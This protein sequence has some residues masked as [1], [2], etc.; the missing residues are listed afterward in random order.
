MVAK[1]VPSM[2]KLPEQNVFSVMVEFYRLKTIAGKDMDEHQ[3]NY[4]VIRLVT[5]IEQFFRCIVEN[6]LRDRSIPALEKVELDTRIIDEVASSVSRSP[7]STIKNR[8]ISLTY[9]FQSTKAI[10]DKFGEAIDGAEK[11]NL[12]KLF[13]HRHNLVHSVDPSP[14]HS[15]EIC[16]H[17]DIVE[18]IMK[19]VLDEQNN[20]DFSFYIMKGQS[21]HRL[22]DDNGSKE[23]FENALNCFNRRVKLNPDNPDLHFGVGLAHWYLGGYEAANRSFD[24]ATRLKPDFAEAHLHRGLMLFLLDR[25]EAAKTSFMDVIKFDPDNAFALLY[26]SLTENAIGS[27]QNA[28]AYLDRAII[29]EPGNARLYAE[30][31]DILR[32]YGM[33]VWADECHKLASMRIQDTAHKPPNPTMEQSEFGS[34]ISTEDDNGGHD[35]SVAD[36]DP[37]AA[38]DG[39][40]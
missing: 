40:P 21:L 24:E 34:Q 37:D 15:E 11:E 25:H 13:K 6:K 31:E 23:C 39:A 38:K 3:K 27:K 29:I 30:K 1:K 16:E 12:D 7:K 18:K 8:I 10:V 4:A 17:Y 14:L 26:A 20:A 33:K 36:K 2:E 35:G 22:R 32:S 19:R 28:L 5:I 9:L